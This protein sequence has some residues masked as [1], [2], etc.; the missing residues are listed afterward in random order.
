MGMPLIGPLDGV[1]MTAALDPQRCATPPSVW[2][3]TLIG[4]CVWHSARTFVAFFYDS[5]AM[6]I[7]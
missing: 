3:F 7:I 4:G 5:V 2:G 6:I 1:A